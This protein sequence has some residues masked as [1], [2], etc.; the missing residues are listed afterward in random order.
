VSGDWTVD[1]RGFT[2]PPTLVEDSTYEV[3]IGEAAVWAFTPARDAHD[4]RVRWPKALR[5]F[6]V[7]RAE[8]RLR[9][10]LSGEVVASASVVLGGDESR[11]IAV[12]DG[13]GN[14]LIIDKSGHI[15]KPLADQD[16]EVRREVL[17]ACHRILDVLEA[18]GVA[19]FIA[20]GTLLGAVRNGRIIGHDNDVDLAYASQ[21]TQPVDIMRESFAI[22]RALRRAGFRVR[23]GMGARVNVR[24]PVADGTIRGIDV[25][26]A[27]WVEDVLYIPSDT[28]FE[29]PRSTLVPT[30][31]IE[32]EGE[33]YPAPGDAETLL[34]HTYGPSWRVPDPS[35]AYETPRWLFRRLAG[36][37]GGMTM[38]RKGWDDFYARHARGRVP[39]QPSAF[40]RW[41][42]EHHPSERRL[43]DLGTGTGR[44]ALYF[45]RRGRP[46]T[47]LDF[48]PGYRRAR[49]R[50]REQ[51][52]PV[53]FGDL[54]LY[55][56]RAVLAWGTALSRS[57]EPVDLYARFVWA[58]LEPL[59]RDNLVRLASMA[60][61]RGGL[62]FL[63]FRTGAE[64]EDPERS[65]ATGSDPAAVLA[66]LRAAG[67]TIVSTTSGSGLAVLGD[68]DPDV[69]RV[70]ARW[71]GSESEEQVL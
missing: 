25:F 10:Y 49:R 71:S 54:N 59:G 24:L 41:V 44:D 32:L 28:G 40:A 51:G 46:V 5:P 19:G 48:A 57:E 17:A 65:S 12:V 61:R 45:A 2:I 9:E 37:Y 60:L 31:P 62:L 33:T 47:G 68:E 69:C 18:Q 8:M 29:L 34:A 23:R 64:A 16:P 30:R 26:T 70:V 6:L 67:A 3:L 66:H 27:A 63:E 13:R 50:A 35:F 14:A 56:T 11:T 42:E 36:W 20:Y 55:D 52:W 1:E 38:H 15:K 4:A 7:G 39:R 22:E 21:R 58:V 43:I 53:T